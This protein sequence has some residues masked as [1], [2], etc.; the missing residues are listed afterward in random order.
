MLQR[1]GRT[2]KTM[3]VP[4]FTAEGSL[5]NVGTVRTRR[6]NEGT[7][8][9][10][11]VRPAITV[12]GGGGGG[13][14]CSPDDPTCVDCRYDIE[15]AL[16]QE[17]QAGGNLQCCQDPNDCAANP[18]PTVD[19]TDPAT[20]RVCFEC[21]PGGGW[22]PNKI[23]CCFNPP[24]NVIPAPALP[25]RCFRLGDRVICTPEISIS[26]GNVAALASFAS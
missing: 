2:M 21:S 24:C 20:A 17:C 3:N 26:S 12:G 10:S 7:P 15:N 8:A 25:P 16:C 1:E 22:D 5:A 11:T 14:Y 19:C 9:T 18:R 6:A 13:W 23:F 4:G